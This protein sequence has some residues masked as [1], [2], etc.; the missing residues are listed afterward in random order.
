MALSYILER[1]EYKDLRD[2]RDCIDN[3]LEQARNH[4]DELGNPYFGMRESESGIRLLCDAP[5]NATPE[6]HII[7]GDVN[8]PEGAIL[9]YERQKGGPCSDAIAVTAHRIGTIFKH[10][11]W[12]T[13]M[14]LKDV[15]IGRCRIVRTKVPVIESRE[16]N[17]VGWGYVLSEE[18][19]KHDS[20]RSLRECIET[21]AISTAIVI[22]IHG[23]KNIDAS[24]SMFISHILQCLEHK[25]EATV[26]C[27]S[28]EFK[29]ISEYKEWEEKVW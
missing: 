29:E 27:I 1:L 19:I 10:P 21:A 7:Y 4:V 6:E 24:I 20:E 9:E 12:R 2:C 22:L 18:H 23:G 14:K 11:E 17:R 8:D 15:K 26:R 25:L 3:L 28:A 5:S 13:V 16:R